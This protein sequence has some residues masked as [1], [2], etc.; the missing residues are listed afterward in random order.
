LVFTISNHETLNPTMGWDDVVVHRG[1][2]VA[3]GGGIG[4]AIGYL[5]F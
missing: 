3:S 5:S 2:I 1:I 4:V